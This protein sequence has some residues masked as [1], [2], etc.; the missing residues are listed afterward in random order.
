MTRS[1]GG[2]DHAGSIDGLRATLDGI[3]AA[4]RTV[5]LWWRDDDLERPTPA[6]DALLDALGGHGIAPALAAVAGRLTP[7]AVAALA[8]SS[9]RLFVHGWLHAD[10]AAPGAR[11]SEFGPER[12]AQ[13]RLAEVAQG[14]QR[15]AALA[16]DRALACFVPPWNRLG[17]DLL[18]RLGEA[19]IA[20]LS[21]FAPWTRPA[22]AA[23]VPRL[24]AHV[25]LVD[26]RGTRLALPAE[27]AAAALEARLRP[28]RSGDPAES[29][30][31]GPIGIL[32]HHLVTGAAAWREWRPL[33]VALC[34]HPAVRWLDPAAALAAV[35]AVAGA[36]NETWRTG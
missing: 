34:G 1:G 29:P 21:G 20:A 12:P 15:L 30:V 5:G 28:P 8:G 22:P 9:A 14:R 25:D 2:P 27:V 17:D 7:E 26:W 19:G 33:L 4:G 6:L 18:G 3:A 13:V 11:K 16:G 36:G 23:A 32:S 24:D 10:H 31:D 35:G